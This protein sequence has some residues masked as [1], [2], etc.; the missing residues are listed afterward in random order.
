[1]NNPSG[2][3]ECEEF[4]FHIPRCIDK[5]M[6]EGRRRCPVVGSIPY[7]VMRAMRRG[8]GSV[9]VSY[10]LIRE[11]NVLL[12]AG[13]AVGRRRK[14]SVAGRRR[15][16]AANSTGWYRVTVMRAV[17]WSAAVAMRKGRRREEGRRKEDEEEGPRH[18][19]ER[20]IVDGV[21]ARHD[22]T[23]VA[24]NIFSIYVSY[25]CITFLSLY[26]D[27]YVFE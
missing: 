5:K 17:R 7:S 15:V 10:A 21:Y 8:R 25:V 1:M 3:E 26:E 13:V 11:V 18:H 2:G 9:G 4:S 20:A 19:D 23:I 14:E 16:E 6:E 27:V 24:N 22:I 12:S